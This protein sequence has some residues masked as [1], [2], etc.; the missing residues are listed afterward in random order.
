MAANAAVWSLDEWLI[1]CC[2]IINLSDGD[3]HGVEL[4]EEEALS[5]V[6]WDRHSSCLVKLLVRGGV[7]VIVI[8]I[9]WL[10][11]IIG[12]DLESNDELSSTSVVDELASFEEE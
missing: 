5:G 11:V 1:E 10:A 8:I 6:D 12:D 9:E 3:G 2:D 4:I 7:L